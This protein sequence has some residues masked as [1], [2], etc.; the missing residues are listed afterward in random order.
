MKG[1]PVDISDIKRNVGIGLRF[2]DDFFSSKDNSHI[3]GRRNDHSID[4]F[5]IN[6]AV[7]VGNEPHVSHW[8]VNF[9][10]AY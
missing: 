5:R 10:R 2:D 7:P 1:E 9:V 4:G 8:T 3:L 6:W